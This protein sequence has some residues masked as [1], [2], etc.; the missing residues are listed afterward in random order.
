MCE[1]YLQVSDLELCEW[2]KDLPII[3]AGTGWGKTHLVMT[4]ELANH[5]EVETKRKIDFILVL[6]PTEAL[7]DEILGK[8][9]FRDTSTK[10]AEYDLL[11]P[12]DDR[13]I[14]RVACFAQLAKFLTD[15][16]EV[17]NKPDLI[18]IDEADQLCYWTLFFKGYC[19]TWDWI[20]AN[21]KFLCLLTATPSLLLD[22]VKKE[23]GLNLIDLTPY[24]PIKYKAKQI[25]IVPHSSLETYLKTIESNSTNKVLAY[26]RSARACKSI[27]ERDK[28]KYSYL[29]SE[30]SRY[31]SDQLFETDELSAFG[32]QEIC[33]R[34]YVTRK[35]KLPPH[36]EVLVINDSCCAGMNLNDPSIKTVIVDTYDLAT[37]L[38]VKGRV[39]ADLEKLVV[40][41]NEKEKKTFLKSLNRAR[42]IFEEDGLKQEIDLATWNLQE[43][44]IEGA[45]I[46]TY[47]CGDE[48]K[49]NP[50][51]KAIY[52]YNFDIY[53]RI[54]N[55]EYFEQLA[56]H[57]ESG[58]IF[59]DRETVAEKARNISKIKGL[60]IEELFSIESDEE[61]KI[62]TVSEL[63]EI[64]KKAGLKDDKG[65]PKGKTAFCDYLNETTDWTIKRLGRKGPNK[66]TLYQIQRDKNGG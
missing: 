49:V 63:Q 9:D 21:R 8:N 56:P 47:K 45:D 52:E 65:K 15:G 14:I 37:V 18:V 50:F 32:K 59:T 10:L 53:Q 44:H 12:I 17:L 7:R 1:R 57:S 58:L 61:S 42:L 25:E 41:Y 19:E 20:L 54:N 24:L 51:A 2:D 11:A 38:Q 40:I 60:N 64:A 23:T 48:V 31:K 35:N 55:K 43:G 36:K 29:V 5:I 66:K 16:N 28:A 46:L 34:K 30:H 26:I 22:Y 62:V 6:V 27:Y 33:L 13:N 3:T 39:R 4:R